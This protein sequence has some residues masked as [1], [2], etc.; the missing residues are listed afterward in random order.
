[1]EAQEL[2]I[3][4]LVMDNAKVKI[5]TS[6]MISNWDIIKRDYG[7]YN[8]IPLTEEWLLKFGFESDGK[9]DYIINKDN[10]FIIC[11]FD[12]VWDDVNNGHGSFVFKGGYSVSFQY[13]HRLQNL[14][15]ALTGEE[16][17]LQT[18]D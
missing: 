1:M 7:G 2:R 15:F 11:Y 4:N 6:G 9:Y 8:P 12:N 5:V 13:V 14:Y 18:N 16:L 3:G 10:F 17:K